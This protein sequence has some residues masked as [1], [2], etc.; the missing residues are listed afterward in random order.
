MEKYFVLYRVSGRIENIPKKLRRK[1]VQNP[2]VGV[3]KK[4]ESH[5]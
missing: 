4:V 2:I 1:C 5:K 3:L